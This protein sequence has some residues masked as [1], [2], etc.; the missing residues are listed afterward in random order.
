MTNPPIPVP[1]AGFRF[2]AAG[3][4]HRIKGAH[5]EDARGPSFR[6]TFSHSPGRTVAGATGDT[7]ADHHHRHG[8]DI[9]LVIGTPP[10]FAGLNHYRPSLVTAAPHRAPD[11]EQ[12]TAVDIGVAE[13]DPYGTRHTTM[14]RPVVPS[15]L[16]ELLLHLHARCP[17][18]PSV[19]IT[20]DDAAD[21]GTVAADDTLT[22]TPKDSYRWYRDLMSAHRAVRK[23][24]R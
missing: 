15:G 6:D 10:D 16:T 19:R 9:A 24:A 13:V 22:R 21:A 4:A 23:D 3:A 14:G 12:G 1:S 8:E 7:A 20:E 2:G 18:P 17:Q 11:A 5:D